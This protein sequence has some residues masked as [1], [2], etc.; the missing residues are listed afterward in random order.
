MEKRFVGKVALVTGATNGIGQ[1]AAVRLAAEGAIVGVNQRPE[2]DPSVTLQKIKDVGGEGF[3][4]VAD[5]RNPKQIVEMVQE[6]A[7]RGG[8]LDYVVSNAGINPFMKWDDTSIEDWDLLSETNLRGTW[9]VTTEGAKQMIKEG[10]GGAIVCTS[11]I[12]AHVG[13]PF[14]SAYCATKGGISM[15]AKAFGAVVGKNGIRVNAV[16][17]G[18]IVTNMSLPMFDDP[19][20]VKYYEE[21]IAIGRAGQPEEMAGVISYLLS[22]DA[23]YVTSATLLVDGGFIVNAEL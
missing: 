18:W 8:R 11:S 6:V 17:P 15:W 22:D 4:V 20:A 16:E 5:M 10:H 7:R 1:A 23:S 9:V 14:Q 19:A 13:S 21:R 2:G 12:S 3:P